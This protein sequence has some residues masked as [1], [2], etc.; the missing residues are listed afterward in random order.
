MG[1]L[2]VFAMNQQ[3][4][5]P[6]PVANTTEVV[7][8][9]TDI[10]RGTL[11]SALLLD[12]KEVTKDAV[13]EGALKNVTA[14]E[15]RM[16]LEAMAKGEIVYDRR[17][18]PKGQRGLA[19]QIKEGM[20]AFTIETPRDSTSVSGLI[21]PGNHVDVILNMTGQMSE[22]MAELTGGGSS[23]TLLQ[24]VEVLAVDNRVE[25]GPPPATVGSTIT[26]PRAIDQ[27]YKSVTLLVTPPQASILTLG[28]SR[29]TLH[30]SLRH[31]NDDKMEVSQPSLFRDL[32]LNMPY[33]RSLQSDDEAKKDESDAKEKKKTE[34]EV[35]GSATIRPRSKRIRILKGQVE[36]TVIHQSVP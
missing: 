3:D 11:V 35:A 4:A 13:G 18:A 1:L 36:Q 20:R 5:K 17:L 25:S 21:V 32:Q 28:Q 27:D 23:L 9:K 33:L 34:T 19:T 14:A 22:E 26:G 24:N 30:L 12:K 7:V 29:G 10:P 8:A 31:P 16:T 6:P 2:A 15:D